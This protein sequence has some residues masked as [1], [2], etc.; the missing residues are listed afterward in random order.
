MDE[1][2]GLGESSGLETH[3]ETPMAIHDVF[4]CSLECGGVHVAVEVIVPLLE[5]D[6]LASRARG[7][8]QRLHRRQRTNLLDTPAVAHQRVHLLLR[9]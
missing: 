5:A 4:P 1:L 3:P 9:K 8:E 2:H 6:I 7:Q